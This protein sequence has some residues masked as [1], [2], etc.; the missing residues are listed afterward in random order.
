MLD[1]H[2]WCPNLID[3]L[4]TRKQWSAGRL[5]P[6]PTR[7]DI[8]NF[9]DVAA[10][11]QS[12]G[13]PISSA[14]NPLPRF[15]GSHSF[16]SRNLP[17]HTGWSNGDRRKA[18]RGYVRFCAWRCRRARRRNGRGCRCADAHSS[19]FPVRNAICRAASEALQCAGV[20]GQRPRLREVD[21]ASPRRRRHAQ[22]RRNGSRRAAYAS[23]GG[24]AARRA[25][26]AR[27][28]PRAGKGDRKPVGPKSAR[29]PAPQGRGP[30]GD[31]SFRRQSG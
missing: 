17:P 19:V 9:S 29:G 13:Y 10:L 26:R 7:P 14:I 3:E 11:H 1:A 15:S 22:T 20:A 12:T 30:A 21:G 2:P 6:R 18:G 16:H 27:G 31:A 5:I 25:I 4:K 28:R 23:G 8:S 24:R